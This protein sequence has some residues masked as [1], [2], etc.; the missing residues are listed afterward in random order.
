M[1]CLVLFDSALQ[2]EC[3]K[4]YSQSEDSIN[5]HESFPSGGTYWDKLKVRPVAMNDISS[6]IY[7]YIYIFQ[8][9]FCLL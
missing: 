2:R 7:I 5:L 3:V 1:T 9:I 6:Y 4:H 8:K